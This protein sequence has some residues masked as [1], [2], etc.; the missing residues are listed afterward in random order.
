MNKLEMKLE[1]LGYKNGIE[2]L[3][4]GKSYKALYRLICNLPLED[5]YNLMPITLEEIKSD[6]ISFYKKYFR[7]HDISYLKPEDLNSIKQALLSGKI[8]MFSAYKQYSKLLN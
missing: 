3:D 2:I 6:A 4:I 5:L 1:Y 8:D 7:V